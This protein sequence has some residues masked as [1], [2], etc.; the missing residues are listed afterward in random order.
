MR[1][2]KNHGG[3]HLDNL[4]YAACKKLKIDVIILKNMS[5]PRH[6]SYI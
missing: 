1:H 3:F 5:I 2:V 4:L 6:S